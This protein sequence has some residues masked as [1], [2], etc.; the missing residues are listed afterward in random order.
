MKQLSILFVLLALAVGVQAAIQNPFDL[1][2]LPV[3]TSLSPTDT[4]VV[5][6]GSG[7]GRK[8][9]RADL[10]NSL[11]GLSANFLDRNL[12]F[13]DAANGSDTNH[14]GVDDPWATMAPA[15]TNTP[16]GWTLAV[17]P[18]TYAGTFTNRQINLYLDVGASVTCSFTKAGTNSIRGNGNLS[19]V[20]ADI[21]ATNASCSIWCDNFNAPSNSA[22][23][24]NLQVKCVTASAYVYANPGSPVP[25]LNL[26]CDSFIGAFTIGATN[27]TKLFLYAKA[28]SVDGSWPLATGSIVAA[29]TL[30]TLGN[31]FASA[32]GFIY[33]VGVTTC[34]GVD[35]NFPANMIYAGDP[36]FDHVISAGSGAVGA[37]QP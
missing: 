33:A 20:S 25:T 24:I 35:P 18:G 19:I 30:N 22:L 32:A 26:E 34:Q 16:A 3:V 23:P 5:V 10:I 31:N 21:G 27:G 9:I 15:Q 28:V 37:H 4:V 12:T 17:A 7:L 14:G 11:N 29:R 6:T 13:L 2:Q 1:N 8:I 36:Y